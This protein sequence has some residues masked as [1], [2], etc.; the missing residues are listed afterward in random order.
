V[1]KGVDRT[2]KYAPNAGAVVGGILKGWKKDGKGPDVNVLL[3]QG[4]MEWTDPATGKRAD[5]KT[6]AE[7][8]PDFHIVLCKTPD[9]SDGPD[10]P[11][12]VNGGKTMICQVGQRGQ[13]IGVVGIYKTASG[14][15]LYYQR[16]VMT[17]EFDTPA[18]K[19]KG[20]P[21]LKLLQDYS[22][23]VRDNDYLSEMARR[24][25]P[26]VAQAQH[27]DAAYVGDAHCQ[28]CHG[29]E[30][31]VWANSKH[32]H[33]YDA[34][35]KIA[36]K[37]SGRNFDG[38]CIVCHTVGYEYRTGYLNEKT[39]P[40]LKNVQCEN[41]HGP[42]SLHVAEEQENLNK[43]ERAQTHHHAALLTP[44]RAGGP[45]KMP[46]LAKLEAMAQEKDHAK[47]E[48][49]LTPAETQVYLGV[50]QTCFGCHDI[51]NDPKFDLAGY[52]HHIAHTGLKKK[53]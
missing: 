18:D 27:K 42:G 46:P 26:H 34:L 17:D 31:A 21:V 53:K 15:E 30:H 36:A 10:M 44:W 51:D 43:R 47:R 40:H 9:D 32:S 4:P 24:K 12:V 50:Y 14:T 23:T 6:A 25:R 8:F 48:A 45:G 16:V 5:A 22:D 41:C 28:K 20:H 7:G 38:E 11:T 37:P 13:S 49:M 29:A 33:A 3:Y 52:W 2:V 19:E 39:T 1:N 35:A